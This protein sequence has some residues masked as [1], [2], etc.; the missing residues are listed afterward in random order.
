MLKKYMIIKKSNL[1]KLNESLYELRLKLNF[2]QTIES[3][4]YQKLID[5]FDSSK[6]QFLQDLFVLNTLDF[7]RD[8]YFIEFGATNGIDLSNSY[9][10]EKKFNW[11]GILAEPSRN[12]HKELRDNRTSHINTECVW[13]KSGEKLL[14]LEANIGEYS[15]LSQTANNDRN[16]HKRKR[17]KKYD[18]TTIS[19]ND[20]LLK[21]EAP[22]EIDYLSIDTEGSEF[23]ILENFDFNK[24]NI[25]VVTCEHNYTDNR[26]KIFSLMCKNGYNRVYQEISQCDDWYVKI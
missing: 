15:S 2:L 19:L 26:E 24:H 14:F 1:N 16:F 23:E 17:A 3:N 13:K 6:S 22:K 5:N 7:K 21:Y 8:G 9:L 4:H 10:L 18:V 25:K 11:H 12:W 20:L